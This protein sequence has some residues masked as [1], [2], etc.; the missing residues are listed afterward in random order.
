MLWITKNN[1]TINSAINNIINKT[2]N[3]KRKFIIYKIFI[4]IMN[5][6]IEYN[7]MFNIIFNNIISYKVV[8]FNNYIYILSI[9]SFII[10]ATSKI[11]NINTINFINKLTI[12]INIIS[13]KIISYK[14]TIFNNNIFITNIVIM[15]ISYFNSIFNIIKTYNITIIKIIKFTYKKIIIIIINKIYNFITNFIAKTSVFIQYYIIIILYLYN[16]II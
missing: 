15:I 16:I 13:S 12:K 9:N 11:I 10:N 6:S 8:T 1:N 7:L 3:L 4:F 14:M 2:T 5:K